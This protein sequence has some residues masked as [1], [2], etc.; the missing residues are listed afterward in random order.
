MSGCYERWVLPRLT[1]LAM[2]NKEVTRYRAAAIPGASGHVL[3]IGAGSGLNLPF[4][5]PQVT[6]LYALDPSGP[7]L[8]MAKAK[9]VRPPF[10]IEFLEANAENIP[11]E[12]G[13]V[14]TV[15]TT[16]TLCSIPDPL[17]ALQEARR[18][19]KAD[20]EL[21]FV[22][23]GLAPDFQ[24]QKWQRR[25]TPLWSRFTGGCHLDRRVGEL[26]RTAGFRIVDLNQAYAKGP[27]PF[28]YFYR[29]RARVG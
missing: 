11:L 3:E 10:P 6:R 5:R 2:R 24:I 4:Y 28:S 17:K 9:P 14:D 18:V 15:V 8:G 7:L 25:L 12:A 16:W 13:S 1:D 20:G 21:V 19:L 26:I 27:R 29:G 23:H 22:E